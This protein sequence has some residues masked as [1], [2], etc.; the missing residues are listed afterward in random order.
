MPGLLRLVDAS[1]GPAGAARRGWWFGFG[2]HLL[3]LY[4]ITEAI[5]I[6]AARYWWF[7]PIAV[8]A[9][10][11]LLAAFIAA[12]VALSRLARPGLPRLLVLAGAWTL[13]DLAREFVLSGFPWNPWG[14][15]WAVPGAVG[16][17][18]IQPA[19][20]IGEPGLTFLTVL[21]AGLPSLTADPIERAR[22]GRVWLAWLSG[23]AVLAG[24]IAFGLIRL[25]LPLPPASGLTVLLVQGNIA[26]GQKWSRAMQMDIFRHYLALTSEAVQSAGPGPKVVVWPETASPFL[27]EFDEGAREAIAAA[28]AGAP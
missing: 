18:F 9:L 12:S 8:P 19:A 26:Q 22:R 25:A 27:L 4:W 21:L 15:V 13:A 6:E 14:S 3:G 20:W 5:M 7:V 11:A 2:H 10:S 28:A 24:W 1:G 16:D 17:V 23:G